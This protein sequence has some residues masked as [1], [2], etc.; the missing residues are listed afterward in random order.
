ML[1]YFVVFAVYLYR[2]FGVL[3]LIQVTGVAFVISGAV[4]VT[5]YSG[6]TLIGRW[7]VS[8]ALSGLWGDG[9]AVSKVE[10]SAR[11]RVSPSEVY[12]AGKLQWHFTCGFDFRYS[13]WLPFEAAFAVLKGLLIVTVGTM[14]LC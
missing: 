8:L 13:L 14:G 5:H 9:W 10:S 12:P 1:C 4:D 11:V 7:F 2:V 3:S 6:F